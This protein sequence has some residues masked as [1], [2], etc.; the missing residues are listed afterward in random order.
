MPFIA[1]ESLRQ[2]LNREKQLSA[3]EAVRIACEVAQAL[4][5]AHA[6]GIVHRDIKPENILLSEGH[7]V[8]ADFG[9]ARAV[10][11]AGD[12]RL[13]ETGLSLGTPAYMSP[14]QAAAEPS[15]DGRS[16]LYALACVLYEMLA[17]Q[18]PFTGSTAQAILARH[19]LDPVP[20]LR[21]V[22]A[23]VP[24][25]VEE[26]ISRA[27]NKVPAERFASAAEFGAAL[28]QGLGSGTTRPRPMLRLLG[29]AA[30]VATMLALLVGVRSWLRNGKA[31]TTEHAITSLA[32]LPFSNLTGD[33]A[34]VYLA[35]GLTDQLV[36]SLA[37]LSALRV[38]N[39]KDTKDVTGQLVKKLGLDAVLAGSFQRAGNAV[40]ITV[41]LNSATT[42]QALWAHGYDGELSGILDLQAEVA[43]WVAS[44]IGASMTPQ[45]R[46]QLSAERPAVS[47]LAYEAYVR[48][49]YFQQKVTRADLDKAIGYF[50]QAIDADPAYAAAWAGLANCYNFLG[51]YSIESPAAAFP[52]R[53]ARGGC[54]VVW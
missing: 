47:S 24:V 44:E 5:C 29:A 38:I 53:S 18:P 21:T 14:E 51:Y 12:Q 35:Q 22:R 2:R 28:V 1:G 40:H 15:L 3:E 20:S 4:S 37:Q 32:V 19:A 54:T 36:T 6:Q 17:G 23:T 41:Q 48:A 9:I 33:T 30:A 49:S 26:A 43:R 10:S 27:L 50:Q 45:E 13:T 52:E 39:L 25:G 31:G 8:V 34:Q 16:D 11:A 42:N 46:A 7:A